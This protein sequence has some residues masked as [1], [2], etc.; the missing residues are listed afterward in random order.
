MVKARQSE[1]S[2]QEV[3]EAAGDI[4]GYEYLMQLVPYIAVRKTKGNITSNNSS[5]EN[6]L[7]SKAHDLEDELENDEDE[8]NA[9]D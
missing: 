3:M 8:G 2:T 1:T 7:L 9:E 4:D 5:T 6:E